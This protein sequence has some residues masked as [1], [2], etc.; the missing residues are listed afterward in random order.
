ML[1]AGAE[2]GKHMECCSPALMTKLQGFQGGFG[3]F[4]EHKVG[5][6]AVFTSFA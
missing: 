5:A 2:V 4:I 1:F 6:T 3:V